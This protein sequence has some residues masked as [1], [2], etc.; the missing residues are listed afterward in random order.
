MTSSAKLQILHNGP[1][2]VSDELS[3]SII[4]SPSNHSEHLKY[5]LQD[6][7]TFMLFVVTYVVFTS[8]SYALREEMFF[9]T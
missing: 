6:L 5:R 9:S 2:S 4:H 7:F 3:D 1:T 8:V